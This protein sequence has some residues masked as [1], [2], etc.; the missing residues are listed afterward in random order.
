MS[1]VPSG[2]LPY[3]SVGTGWANAG[4]PR[5]IIH[6]AN[7]RRPEQFN[8]NLLDPC[9][10]VLRAV[11]TDTGKGVPGANSPPGRWQHFDQLA[12]GETWSLYAT[13]EIKIK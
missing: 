4:G 9:D 8:V 2:E 1:L 3:I 13:G 6:V 11:D 5:G 12:D 10:L 7:M